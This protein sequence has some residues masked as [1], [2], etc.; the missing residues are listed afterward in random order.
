MKKIILLFVMLV[1][2]TGISHGQCT[3]ITLDEL[4]KAL[5][6]DIA[7]FKLFASN[8]GMKLKEDGNETIL[9]SCNTSEVYSWLSFTMYKSAGDKSPK[10][11][12]TFSTSDS[13]YYLNFVN[14]ILPKNSFTFYKMLPVN[15]QDNINQYILKST[16]ILFR[17]SK[18]TCDLSQLVKRKANIIEMSYLISFYK[19]SLP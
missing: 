15:N 1:T 7:K 5:D 9:Y 3:P 11:Y 4:E 2:I 18:Y 10:T 14:N 16:S 6:F 13:L 8:K 17:N 19:N 12:I